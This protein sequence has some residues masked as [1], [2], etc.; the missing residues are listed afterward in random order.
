MRDIYLLRRLSGEI[1]KKPKEEKKNNSKIKEKLEV[2]R[3]LK[4]GNNK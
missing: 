4:Y 2:K 1:K 3:G